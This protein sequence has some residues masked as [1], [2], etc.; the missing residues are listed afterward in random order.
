MV[1]STRPTLDLTLSVPLYKFCMSCKKEKEPNTFEQ[2]TICYNRGETKRCYDPISGEPIKEYKYTGILFKNMRMERN[3]E[4]ILRQ[5]SGDTTN[6]DL[7]PVSYVERNTKTTQ[8]FRERTIIQHSVNDQIQIMVEGNTCVDLFVTFILD[9]TGSMSDL[10]NDAIE[11]I[12]S[13][14]GTY[15]G[16]AKQLAQ[17][18]YGE[19]VLVNV[20]VSLICY[21]DFSDKNDQIEYCTY[22]T[23]INRIRE[24]LKSIRA[25]GGG[26]TPEDLWG[27]F[28]LFLN[29]DTSEPM[30]T[31]YMKG[32]V[33]DMLTYVFIVTDAPGHG[34]FMTERETDDSKENRIEQ[35]SGTEYEWKRA[36]EFMRDEFR[37]ELFLVDMNPGRINKMI[38]F[39]KSIYDND[40]YTMQVIPY[41]RSSVSRTSSGARTGSSSEGV[42]SRTM[43]PTFINDSIN[44]VRGRR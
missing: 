41:N 8:R 7:V 37:A 29:T 28:L 15:S 31:R 3:V 9:V 10:I 40:K 38:M 1:V 33:E 44:R 39:L 20:M 23:D 27:A 32:N 14:I 36:I 42:F 5:T 13:I 11:Q 24:I 4:N 19:D 6:T 43:E 2:C 12:E 16:I 17:E 25:F 26:D 35:R 34:K 30:I 22:T 18:K 21:R